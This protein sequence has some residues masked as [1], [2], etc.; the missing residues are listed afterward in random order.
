MAMDGEAGAG[1]EAANA[2]WCGRSP[3][4]MRRLRPA[5]RA[6]D[7]RGGPAAG[8]DGDAAGHDPVA[9]LH[10]ACARG[11]RGIASGRRPREVSC[12]AA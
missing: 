8:Q 12:G 3:A 2:G 1:G 11:E 9:G 5:R 6:I 7:A 10:A 4:G